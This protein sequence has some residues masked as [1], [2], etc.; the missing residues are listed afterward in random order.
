MT[1]QQLYKWLQEIPYRERKNS[2]V[3]M[4][5]LGSDVAGQAPVVT[6]QLRD[7]DGDGIA[8]RVELIYK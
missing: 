3:W 1:A 8:D 2:Q 7:N 5:T 6:A 4:D